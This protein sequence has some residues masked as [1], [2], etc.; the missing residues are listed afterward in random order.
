MLI[1]GVG[2]VVL[3]AT[4]I[5]IGNVDTFDGALEDSTAITVFL[6]DLALIFT[7]GAVALAGLVV[8]ALRR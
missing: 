6:A 5:G 7:G 4:V 8:I 2:A 3:G 1:V